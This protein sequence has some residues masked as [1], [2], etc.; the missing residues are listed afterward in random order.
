MRSTPNPTTHTRDLLICTAVTERLRNLQFIRY[1]NLFT[2]MAS[3]NAQLIDP[4]HGWAIAAAHH[5]GFH[6]YQ[7]KTRRSG[8]IGHTIT[9]T[10]QLRSG[11]TLPGPMNPSF[12]CIMLLAESGF[13]ISSMSP[14][15]HPAW[16][17]HV[18]NKLTT[19]SISLHH[20]TH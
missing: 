16:C 14:R 10:G 19:E 11:K 3:Q 6:Y 8:S 13:G 12:C 4:C 20:S 7:L 5:T 18:P 1:T 15:P 17:Q 2:E 9:K